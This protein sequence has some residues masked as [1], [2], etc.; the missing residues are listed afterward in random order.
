[1]HRSPANVSFSFF[2]AERTFSFPFS[3][4]RDIIKF[5]NA[6]VLKKAV[7]ELMQQFYHATEIANVA[8]AV[9]ACSDQP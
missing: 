1:M 9:K 2:P 3:L 5:L 7:S 4:L 6:S 8:N